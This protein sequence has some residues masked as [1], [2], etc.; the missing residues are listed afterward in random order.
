V[1]LDVDQ[2]QRDIT[3]LTGELDSSE[4]VSRHSFNEGA[5]RRRGM[6]QSA[7]RG[8]RRRHHL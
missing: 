3:C 6:D 2:M 7:G 8:E 1:A 5:R 4:I